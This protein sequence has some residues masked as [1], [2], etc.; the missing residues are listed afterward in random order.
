MLH[1]LSPIPFP[2]STRQRRWLAGLTPKQMSSQRE[3]CESS[4]LAST[5]LFKVDLPLVLRREE[6]PSCL[7]G[8]STPITMH[9]WRGPR[10]LQETCL[11]SSPLPGTQLLALVPRPFKV[12]TPTCWRSSL[13][14]GTLESSAFSDSVP[15]D[16]LQGRRKKARFIFSH[17]ATQTSPETHLFQTAGPSRLIIS[18]NH[19]TSIS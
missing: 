19:L 5:L 9:S 18:S 1:H 4:S 2:R 10:S 8:R 14:W 7:Q 16:R 17:T 6:H 3:R 12:S 11:S 13:V 15:H